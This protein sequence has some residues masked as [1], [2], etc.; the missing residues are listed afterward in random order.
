MHDACFNFDFSRNSSSYN[1]NCNFSKRTSQKI[2]LGLKLKEEK[3]QNRRAKPESEYYPN[4]LTG[5]AQ[6]SSQKTQNKT[7]TK[8]FDIQKTKK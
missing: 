8:S 7:N 5:K 3:M 6:E 1:G 4:L 2:S